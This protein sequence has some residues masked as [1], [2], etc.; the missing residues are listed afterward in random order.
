VPLHL[1][2]AANRVARQQQHGVGYRYAHDE[3][4]GVA[5]MPCLPEALRDRRFY[6]P[7]ERGFETKIAE[8]LAEADRRRR[9]DATD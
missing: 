9:G 5:P 6:E 8:R 4:S 3:P 1:R 2:N 7:G